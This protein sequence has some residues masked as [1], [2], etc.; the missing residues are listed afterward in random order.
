[1]CFLAL[2]NI[3]GKTN[4]NSLQGSKYRAKQSAAA[5]GS[6]QQHGVCPPHGPRH[7]GCSCYRTKQASK[8][9]AASSKQHRVCSPH[10]PAAPALHSQPQCVCVCVDPHCLFSYLILNTTKK[11]KGTRSQADMFCQGKT[12]YTSGS[13][14]IGREGP[15]LSAARFW[16]MSLL[17][18]CSLSCAK[19]TRLRAFGRIEMCVFCAWKRTLREQRHGLESCRA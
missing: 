4:M 13:S 9:Q 19:T 16:P 2:A 12:E 15:P 3:V 6:T 10:G 11:N 7:I 17:P 1:M 8:Q 5:S 14:H 18:W